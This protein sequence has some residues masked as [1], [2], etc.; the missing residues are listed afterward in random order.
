[1]QGREVVRD[2]PGAHVSERIVAA[3]CQGWKDTS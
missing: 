3:G 1:M 2:A